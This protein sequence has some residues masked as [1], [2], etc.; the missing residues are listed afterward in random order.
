[1][2]PLGAMPAFAAASVTPAT[3]GSAIL[4]T[5]AGGTYTSLT[6]PVITGI[7]DNDL[8]SSGTVTLVAPSG[9]QFDIGGTAPTVLVT[10]TSS[11]G[12]GSSNN[13]N[14]VTQAIPSL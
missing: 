8:D 13:V 10:C 1:M 11:C 14:N 5:T 7:D 12:G 3:G 4:S 2:V 9:F 6:G